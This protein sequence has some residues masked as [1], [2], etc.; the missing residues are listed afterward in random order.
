M[1]A[2]GLDHLGV[3]AADLDA[4]ARG[5]QALGFAP[6][7]LAR[8]LADGVP[9][10]TGNRNI[11]LRQGYI[12]LLA[13]I[14]PARPSATLAGMLDH[15]PGAHILTLAVQDEAAELARL[16][17][18]GFTATIAR[19]ARAADPDAPDGPAARFARIALTDALPRL[20]LLHQQTPE[21]VWQE[22]FLAHPNRAVA[23][24]CVFVVADPPAAFAARLSRVAGL[25]MV[26]DPAGGYALRMPAGEV[27]V[28]P[29]A[30]VATVLPGA[31]IPALP[32]IVALG[33]RTDDANLAVAHLLPDAPRTADGLMARA[34]GVTVLFLP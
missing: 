1:S 30:A 21:L 11:M 31:P 9:T 10:G 33:V 18:A 19:S 29:S 32:A 13:T 6:L 27:R 23:L 3:V 4:A 8:H 17:R 28:L 25:P 22:R 7:P 12:E 20:Q 34:G 16:A 14:D 5:W 15:H 24:C 26:P 2:T